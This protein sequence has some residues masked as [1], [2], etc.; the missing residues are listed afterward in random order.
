MPAVSGRDEDYQLYQR[1]G[2][3]PKETRAPGSVVHSETTSATKGKQVYT[4]ATQPMSAGDRA[5]SF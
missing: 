5:G 3:C 2:S 4:T 1:S